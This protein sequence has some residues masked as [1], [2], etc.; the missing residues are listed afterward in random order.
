MISLAS[1]CP[2]HFIGASSGAASFLSDVTVSLC[3]LLKSEQLVGKLQG[4]L[5]FDPPLEPSLGLPSIAAS[6]HLLSE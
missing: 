4:W 3:P 2:Q 5:F 6:K 1:E